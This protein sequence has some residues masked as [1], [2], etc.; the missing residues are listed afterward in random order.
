M[1]APDSLLQNR[2]RIIRQLGQ[3]GMGTVYEAI[4]Q[5]LDTAVAL[6]ES[7]FTE[8][9]LR[10]QFEREARLLAKL[11][12]PAMTRVSDH[13]EES[14]GQFLVMDFIPGTDL[15]EMLQHRDSP[16]PTAEVLKWADQL[17]DALDYLHTQEPPIIHRDIKP[18]N[19]KLTGR[20]QV[21]L[22]DFGLAKG[23]GGNLSRLTSTGSIFGYTP[24]YAPLEQ[25]QGTGTSPRSDLYSLSATLYHLL[26]NIPPPDALTRATASVSEEP[27]PL[28]PANELSSQVTPALAAVLKRA[29]A[30]N[31]N[32]RP[33][34]SAEMRQALLEANNLP[35]QME[36]REAATVLLPPTIA[37]PPPTE[38]AQEQQG[39]VNLPPT[40]ASVETQKSR[41]S[42][43]TLPSP[44]IQTTPA[45]AIT[46][47][48]TPFAQPPSRSSRLPW[49][50]ASLV[51]LLIVGVIAF[52][53]LRNSSDSDSSAT[54][55]S[56]KGDSVAGGSVNPVVQSS[57]PILVGVFTDLSGPTSSLGQSTINGIRTAA[58]EVNAAGGING[59]QIEL[60]IED[61]QG[62]SA[63][64]ATD[65]AKL[66]NQDRVI[67][68]L[69]DVAST[70]TLAAAPT[71]QAAHVPLISP[72]STN[73]KVAQIGDY[74][75]RASFVD[76]FQGEAMA[77]FAV[78]TLKARRAA[79]LLDINSDYS[80]GLRDSF[81]QSFTKLG[82]SFVAEQSYMGRDSDFSAQLN[83][84][85]SSNPDVIYLPGFYH[86]VGLIA[87]QARQ[88]GINVPIL[89]GDGWDSPQLWD[90]GG[91]AL[92]GS[93]ITNHYAVDDP[94]PAVQKFV[95]AYK[96]RYSSSPDAI[97]ALAYDAMMLLADALR[98]AG[99]TGGP[100]LRDAIAQTKNFNGV[101]GSITIN[102]ERN[103]VKP[104]AIL[105]LR[106]RQFVYKETIQP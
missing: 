15:W 103:A 76:P 106:N 34:S 1:L 19:L 59:R 79:I 95:T 92:N 97:A 64:A 94:S 88:L 14:D 38:K 77:K 101:T 45:S 28:R 32:Q 39:P 24:N 57:G 46:P 13:F 55:N 93:F 54:N 83:S 49:I 87:K 70:N 22:L 53:A 10:K 72:A 43:Q 6:K 17:L 44:P 47:L 42:P 23:F 67:A 25:I 60:A 48:T 63:K 62:E 36:Q 16:F 18:Q 91:D 58:D 12:H 56:S 11:R 41:P 75:F 102:A 90:I 69:G 2:Y 85:R 3:G 105:E 7:H 74:I 27:D 78:N 86:N 65:V 8:E 26:T 71:A 84:I 96:A 98:R 66:I 29:M 40:V 68:L 20:G 61:N 5:R 99:T 89:G 4:D 81:K 104:V 37:S 30:L 80:K 100:K 21:I 33:A 51:G 50:I 73:P 35:A 52:I 9:R 31:P 82:G